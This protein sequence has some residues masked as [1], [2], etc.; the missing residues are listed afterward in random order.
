MFLLTAPTKEGL[1]MIWWKSDLQY[2]LSDAEKNYPTNY[3]NCDSW[4]NGFIA[5]LRVDPH[6]KPKGTISADGVVG[7]PV[8]KFLPE[9]YV[10]PEPER[11]MW[12]YG[13]YDEDDEYY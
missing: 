5:W 9:G 8:A 10:P 7:S 1:Y 11:N 12:G 3:D 2:S 4:Y 13:N 6:L